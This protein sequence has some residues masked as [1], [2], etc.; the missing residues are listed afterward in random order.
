MPKRGKTWSLSFLESCPLLMLSNSIIT[1]CIPL[2]ST[3]PLFLQ[4]SLFKFSLSSSLLK[5]VNFKL[6]NPLSLLPCQVTWPRHPSSRCM[7]HFV[8]L[9]TDQLLSSILTHLS[10]LPSIYA[11]TAVTF[12][13]VA[14]LYGSWINL[15]IK[16]HELQVF[17]LHNFLCGD[18]PL[19]Y[20]LN[21]SKLVHFLFRLQITN[22]YKWHN[23]IPAVFNFFHPFP[24]ILS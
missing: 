14:F 6:M 2:V 12:K 5:F 16:F 18:F 1:L 3:A 20:S 24:D 11:L 15:A 8:L 10:E 22:L 17:D 7:N 9:Y 4:S 13:V 19:I 23:N 21:T